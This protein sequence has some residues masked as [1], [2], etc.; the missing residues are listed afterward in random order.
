MKKVILI[1]GLL[2][3]SHLMSAENTEYDELFETY[4]ERYNI[5]DGF[6]KQVAIYESGLNHNAKKEVLPDG[7][8]RGL[9]LIN[10]R[11]YPEIKADGFNPEV[12]ISVAS[13]LAYSC[14]SKYGKTEKMIECFNKY[15]EDRVRK[16]LQILNK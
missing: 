3:S 9:F 11:W 6:L 2:I 8:E 16:L 10:D 15:P 4:S 12:S 5:P 7:T 13:K 1:I 14:I